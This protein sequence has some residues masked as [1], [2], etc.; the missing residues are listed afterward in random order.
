MK[1]WSSKFEGRFELK[2]Y[3]L[4]INSKDAWQH[5]RDVDQVD[6]REWKENSV[7]TQDFLII[8]HVWAADTLYAD[9]SYSS[10]ASTYVLDQPEVFKKPGSMKT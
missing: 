10:K 7:K 4:Y 2:G 1:T 8:N 6:Q 3:S 9:P 5:V